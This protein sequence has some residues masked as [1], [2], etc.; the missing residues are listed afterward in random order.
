MNQNNFLGMNTDLEKSDIVILDIPYD[1]TTS[2]RPGTRFAGNEIRINSLI[3]YET[4][5]PTFDLDLEDLKICD[6]GSIEVPL[7]D[8]KIVQEEIKKNISKYLIQEKKL[9]IIGGEHSITHG[10]IKAFKEKYEELYVI[11]F[12]A[13]TDLREEYLGSKYSHASAMKRVGETIDP[14]NLFQFGIRSGT[15]EEFSFGK[16]NSGIFKENFE[17]L[18]ETILKLKNKNVYITIDLDVLDPAFFPGTGTPE[19][20]GVT[21]KELFLAI[22]KLKKL[23]NVVG[24]DVV[25]LSPKLDSSDCSTAV[26]I[27][28]L[29]EMLFIL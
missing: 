22:E 2:F 23:N 9:A 12:D 17:G 3:G 6:E 5:S 8:P 13:H 14:E 26:A 18:E 20:N 16:K 28:V 1:G 19:P 24:F 29:R 11:Q 21:S 4:Y 15:R 10:I 25:E 7:T 27:K